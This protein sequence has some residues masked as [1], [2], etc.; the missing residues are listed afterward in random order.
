VVALPGYCP[1][2]QP[3][4]RFRAVTVETQDSVM[5]VLPAERRQAI[6]PWFVMPLIALTMFYCLDR[7]METYGSGPYGLVSRGAASQAPAEAGS[8]E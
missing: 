5:S 2:H 7:L 1:F 3:G 8:Q 4:G 6:W